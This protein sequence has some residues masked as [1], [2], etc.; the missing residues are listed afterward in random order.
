M[1]TPTD[2]ANHRKQRGRTAPNRALRLRKKHKK[3]ML[4]DFYEKYPNAP[5]DFDGTPIMC[6][7]YVGLKN[8][9]TKI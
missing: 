2:N 1:C 6:P 3:T 5:I 4:E 8:Y 7:S 9:C